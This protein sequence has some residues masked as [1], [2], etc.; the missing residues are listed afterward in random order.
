MNDQATAVSGIVHPDLGEIARY[1]PAGGLDSAT[2]EADPTRLQVDLGEGHSIVF[3]A[4]TRSGPDTHRPG[5]GDQGP[6]HQRRHRRH[7]FGPSTRPPA[8]ATSSPPASPRSTGTTTPT[9]SPPSSGT[10]A[11]TRRRRETARLYTPSRG[12][13]AGIP[14]IL[15]AD[16][17]EYGTNDLDKSLH[18]D[19]VLQY[20]PPASSRRPHRLAHALGVGPNWA[21]V[22]RCTQRSPSRSRSCW[23]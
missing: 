4:G 5:H 20:V 13:H 3:P 23:V 21:C 7:H 16:Y 8:S 11:P 9:T 6:A 1:L 12:Q 15:T 19:A 18:F 14:P 17:F 10:S 2:G 22:V